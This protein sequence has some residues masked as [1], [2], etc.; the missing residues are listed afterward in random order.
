[1]LGGTAPNS[2]LPSWLG[3]EESASNAG[4]LGD[5]GQILG[6]GRAPAGGNS[7]PLQQS[8]WENPMNRGAWQDTTCGVARVG[9][10]EHTH[11]SENYRMR[12]VLIDITSC[13]LGTDD[14]KRKQAERCGGRYRCPSS[15]PRVTVRLGLPWV[16]MQGGG[17]RNLCHTERCHLC[18]FTHM[19]S[20]GKQKVLSGF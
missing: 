10:T 2:G 7:N 13:P 18:I 1:M 15:Q 20:G 4:D 11:T 8:C 3:S 17:G 12:L 5:E 16:Q 19:C 9:M 14:L 6:S